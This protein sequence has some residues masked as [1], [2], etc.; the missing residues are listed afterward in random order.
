M[1]R[2]PWRR[3]VVNAT[4]FVVVVGA[5][6][7][8]VASLP[9]DLVVAATVMVLI[10]AVGGLL[11]W[12]HSDHA[13]EIEPATWHATRSTE[14][15]GPMSLDYRLVRLRRDL[16]DALERTDR[17]DVVHPLIC[18]LAVERVRQKHGVDART[19]PQEAQGHLP[20]EL[21]DYLTHPPEGT[22]RRSAT[23]LSRMLDHLE[24]I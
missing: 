11:I 7:W 16:R 15:T 20:A 2:P 5:L 23:E 8:Y 3:R 1:K 12:S 21:W 14:A 19:D 10:T 13:T 4:G 17:E 18:D 22:G 9:G 6:L 24:R